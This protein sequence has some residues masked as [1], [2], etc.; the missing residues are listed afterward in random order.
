M[1]PQEIANSCWAFATMR[2]FP[3]ATVLDRMITYAGLRRAAAMAGYLLI[4][5]AVR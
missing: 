4:H 1:K 5:V 2:F 3:G